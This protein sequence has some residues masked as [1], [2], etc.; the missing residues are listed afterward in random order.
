LLAA[1][2]VV[3]Q[4]VVVEAQAVIEQPLDSLLPKEPI[5]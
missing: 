2:E 5:L 4:S 3:L 1:V